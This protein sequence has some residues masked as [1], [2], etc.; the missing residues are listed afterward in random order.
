LVWDDPASSPGRPCASS[1]SFQRQSDEGG[2]ACR[3]MTCCSDF[4]CGGSRW[5][6]RSGCARP[7]GRWAFITRPTTA[8]RRS[9]TGGVWRRSG[10]RA[11]TPA[12]LFGTTFPATLTTTA[13]DRSSSR[14]FATSAYGGH[15]GPPS[16]QA[17]LL[18]LLHSTAS[19][20]WSSPSSLLQRSW[21]HACVTATDSKQQLCAP[22][23]TTASNSA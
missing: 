11:T 10:G 21:S 20:L 17:Q 16:P 15:G 3:M 2:S 19:G 7:V 22:S 18:H 8:G 9:S 6:R 14:W 4:A 12:A 1:G 13:L 5:P 23:P